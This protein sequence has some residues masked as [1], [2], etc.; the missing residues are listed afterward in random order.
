MI[1]LWNSFVPLLLSTSHSE[2]VEEV[3]QKIGRG[4]GA[5]G[6][7]GR[8]GGARGVS[9]VPQRSLATLYPSMLYHSW[10]R[11]VSASRGHVKVSRAFLSIGQ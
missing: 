1:L 11:K 9:C 10:S 7:G 2:E 5:Q 3:E 8:Q 6:R 4:S